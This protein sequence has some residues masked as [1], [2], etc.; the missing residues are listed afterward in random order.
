MNAPDGHP[1]RFMEEIDRIDAQRVALAKRQ[2]F[3]W[4]KLFR[5]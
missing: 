3:I 4:P 5:A 1:L 2:T